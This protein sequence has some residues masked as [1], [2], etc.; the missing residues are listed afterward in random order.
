MFNGVSAGWLIYQNGTNIEAYINGV[1][2]QVSRPSTSTWTHIALTR[3]G[4][5]AGAL[6][7]SSTSSLG[8]DQTSYGLVFGGDAT[9]RN[10]L[11]GF[12]DEFRLT[13]GKARYTSNFTVPTEAFPNL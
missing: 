2:L 4:T 5:T 13:L 3:D 11:D 10:G 6:Q 7:I 9:G 8:A 12:I 1:Q